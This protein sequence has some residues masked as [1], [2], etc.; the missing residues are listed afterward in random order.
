ME[1]DLTQNGGR[2]NPKWKMTSHKMEDDLPQNGR[3]PKIKAT[4]KKRQPKMKTS[5]LRNGSTTYY[6]HIVIF[7]PYFIIGFKMLV[8]LAIAAEMLAV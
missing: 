4:K 6:N 7:S 1:D 8:I 5:N 2:P 3:L